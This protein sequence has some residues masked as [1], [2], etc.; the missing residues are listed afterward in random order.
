MTDGPTVQPTRQPTDQQR[1]RP[2][3]TEVTFPTN[4]QICW[5]P[6]GSRSWFCAPELISNA[7]VRLRAA[8]I[9]N[10]SGLIAAGVDGDEGGRGGVEVLGVQA[11]LLKIFS[12]K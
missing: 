5:Y 6:P 4:I 2:G 12:A 11:V 3:H 10:G 9:D 1:K 8:G 7:W